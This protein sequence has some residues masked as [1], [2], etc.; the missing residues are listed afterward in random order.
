MLLDGGE[1][2]K[3]DVI[4]GADGMSSMTRTVVNDTGFD[5]EETGQG[6]ASEILAVG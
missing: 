3:A 4:I 5:V 2:L 1:T 6:E